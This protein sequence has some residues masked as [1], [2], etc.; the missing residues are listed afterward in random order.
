MNQKHD[1]NYVE[2]DGVIVYWP[3]CQVRH[4]RYRICKWIPGPYCFPHSAAML[5]VFVPTSAQSIFNLIN[6]TARFLGD[7]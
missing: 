7:Q 5:N 2:V 4:C 1:P 6:M 3:R